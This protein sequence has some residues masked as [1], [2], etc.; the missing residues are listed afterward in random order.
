M[1]VEREREL[2]AI[3][4]LLEDAREGCGGVLVIHAPAGHG[5]TRLIS[6]AGDRARA[7]G[8]G[9]LGA[10]ATELEREFPFGVAVQLLEPLWLAAGA[11]Q[12]VRLSTGAASVGAEL[13]DGRLSSETTPGAGAAFA[14]I[15]GLFSFVRHLGALEHPPHSDGL[16][17]LIDDAHW[18]DGPS[19]RFLAYLAERIDPLPVAVIVAVR[20]GESS[21]EPRAL[22]ALHGAAGRQVLS[23]RALSDSGVAALVR[24]R[25]PQSTSPFISTCAEVTSG[26]PFLLTKL[27]DEVVD[28][29]LTP[30]AATAKQLTEMTPDAVLESVAGRLAGLSDD[31]VAVARALAVLGDGS[32]VSRVAEFAEITMPVAALAADALA[33]HHL[34]R[35]G[36]PLSFAHP[37][38]QSSVRAAMA[39]LE[40][41]RAHR[42]AALMLL[43]QGASAEAVAAQL[44]HAPAEADPRA[45][46][47]LVSAARHAMASGAPAS[48]VRLLERARAEQPDSAQDAEV[49]GELAE[50]EA[51]SGV[52]AAI[53]HLDQ[54]IAHTTSKQRRTELQLVLVNAYLGQARH[55]DAASVVIDTLAPSG[56]SAPAGELDLALLATA[57]F[58]PTLRERARDRSDELMRI[59]GPQPSELERRALAA[60]AVNSALD[61]E[62]RGRVREMVERAW[63][64]GALL[65]PTPPHD[66]RMLASALYFIDDLE[67][68]VELCDAAE[69]RGH[70]PGADELRILSRSC[71]AWP[72]YAQG[73]IDEALADARAALDWLPEDS[74]HL[75]SQRT[76]YGAL[77]LCLTDRG[78]LEQADTALS[79]LD[80]PGSGESV[81][82]PALLDAR[83]RLRLAQR[84]PEEALRDAT[85]AGRAC[86]ELGFVTPGAVPWRTTRA[87][88]LNA[89][90]EHQQAHALAG[91]ALELARA[92]GV[93]RIVARATRILGLT[94]RGKSRDKLL[95]LAVD[96]CEE[97]PQRREQI[98]CLLAWGAALRRSNQ[99]AAAREPLQRA[100]ELAEAGG[101]TALADA[102]RAE[103]T[104]TGQHARRKLQSGLGSLTP[105]ERSVAELACSGQT[106][107]AMAENLFVSPK[108]IEYHLRQ[109]Y[110]K[111]DIS[112]RPQLASALQQ[113]AS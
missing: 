101:A 8:L 97:L 74:M 40:R 109:I 52:P 105:R 33:A 53:D 11:E 71:R 37:L 57:R 26:N 50:A 22:S 45:V 92:I 25:L 66:W 27:I 1:L 81:H 103:L 41:A 82:Y 14:L 85:D 35:P 107:R 43:E 86:A 7:A 112:S 88:A 10:Q 13:L 104:A 106:T 80:H 98:D 95:R 68:D 19:W 55:A 94:S 62:K 29:H 65:S 100:L 89:L 91:E 108:T 42:R 32:P 16:V 46:T 84:R 113:H 99:R 102:A 36:A 47:A 110:R 9:V 75:S 39:P 63:C 3:D 20:A 23:P 18:A 72:L 73:R 69:L 31:C 67:R 30:N 12:R 59:A 61:G 15:H 24:A 34:L 90:G 96:L 64:A 51:A 28:D 60:A 87:L 44:L 111:L 54:A 38:I 93:G 76:C 4:R 83:A 21:P 6:V 49:L 78:E 2:A 56:S 77:A 70:E 48:A 58:V 79:I 5:K 17:M